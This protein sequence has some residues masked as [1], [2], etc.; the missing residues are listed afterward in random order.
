M[1]VAAELVEVGD[2]ERAQVDPQRLVDVLQRHAQG[3]DL[4]PVD[5]GEELRRVGAELG[6]RA[7]QAGLGLQLADQFVGLLLQGVQPRAAPVLDH[8][9]EAARD[10]EARDR[11]RPEGDSP[12][13]P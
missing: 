6:G 10:A 7:G 5:V 3:G 12:G 13:R 1:P 11:R 2:V 9:L 4:G 8:E